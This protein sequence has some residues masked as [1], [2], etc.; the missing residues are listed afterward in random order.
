MVVCYQSQQDANPEA[1]NTID[2]P[3][4]PEYGKPPSQQQQQK[5]K[6]VLGAPRAMHYADYSPIASWRY[7]ASGRHTLNGSHPETEIGKFRSKDGNLPDRF[8]KPAVK[9]VHFCLAMANT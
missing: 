2:L 3:V 5:S 6:S 7:L 9:N 1:K 4:Y 8:R